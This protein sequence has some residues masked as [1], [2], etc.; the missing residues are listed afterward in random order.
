MRRMPTCP[1]RRLSQ[2]GLV[3]MPMGETTPMP[4]MT[5][6]FMRGA[7]VG[8]TLTRS[9]GPRAGRDRPGRHRA[10]FADLPRRW[11][12]AQKSFQGSS[13]TLPKVRKRGDPICASRAGTAGDEMET[14]EAILPVESSA[15]AE[16]VIK[17]PMEVRALLAL[18]GKPTPAANRRKR[19]RHPL[20]LEMVLQFRDENEETTNAPIYTRD[21]SGAVLGFITSTPPKSGQQ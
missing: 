5:T 9:T 20:R 18:L 6:R 2:K 1:A 12:V 17:W 15:S 14:L 21:T 7:I 8:E 11:I 13:R 4:V 19:P 3:P 10:L 16:K